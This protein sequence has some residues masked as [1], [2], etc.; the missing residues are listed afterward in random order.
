MMNWGTGL[1]KSPKVFIYWKEEN[2]DADAPIPF[3]KRQEL[4]KYFLVKLNQFH[5]LLQRKNIFFPS[6]PVLVKA[7]NLRSTRVSHKDCD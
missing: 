7:F 1:K 5:L 6:S 3:N 2:I 4:L